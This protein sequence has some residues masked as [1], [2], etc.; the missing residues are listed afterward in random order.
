MEQDF[1][2]VLDNL[3]AVLFKGY[4]DGSIDLFDRKVESLTGYAQEEFESRRLK[5]S[6]LI[7][8]EDLDR[9][10]EEFIQ[11][12][13][14]DKAYVREFRIRNKEGGIVW[15]HE[16]SH[17]IRDGQGR[18]EYISGLFFDITEKKRLEEEL[19]QTEQEF[20]IVIDNIPAVLGKGYLDGSMDP[21]DHK[22]EAVTG[23]S[24]ED[25][26]SRRLKLTDLV[27]PEDLGRI[28][29]T[30]IQALKSNKA[31]V[32]EYRIR[33]KQGNVVWILERSHI[34]RNAQG[35]G[36]YI[37]GLFFDITESKRIEEE[38]RQ[39][40]QE[41]RIVID[42]IPAVLAKGYLD[43][44][45]DT[46]DQK[47]EFMTG[48]PR[49]EFESR[50]LKWTDLI[51]DAD[52]DEAKEIFVHALKGDKTYVR[53]YRI[54]NKRGDIIWIHERGHILCNPDGQVQYISGFFFDI[55]DRK[56]LE[57]TVAEQ[58]A[59]LKEANE[60]LMVWSK[61]LE[62]RNTEI[63]LLGQMGELLQSC[64][65]IEEAYIAIKQ[66]LQQLFPYDSGALYIFNPGRTLVEAT[67]VWGE[68]P[69]AEMVVAP[70]E[71]WALRRGRP[72]GAVEIRAGF[73]CRH[74][75]AENQAYICIPL[76][77]HGEAIGMFHVLLDSPD[78]VQSAIKQ[79]LAVRV[80]EYLGLALAKLKLQETLQRLSVRDPL[81]GLYNR[82]HLEE[83]MERELRRAERQGKQVGVIM[84]DID[85]FKRFNDTYGHEAGDALLREMGAFLQ[86]HIRGNDLAC[87]YGGEEF[88][89]IL[90]DVSTE[91]TV[92]RAEQLREAVKQLKVL[93]G[94]GFL[95]PITLS[96]GVAM[97]PAHGA[98]L[99]AVLQAADLALYRAKQTGRDRVCLSGMD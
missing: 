98:T 34:I 68:T 50:R 69:P 56:E 41:F 46:Y 93:H 16:R 48:Y 90:R 78:P 79:D 38:L 72:H 63:S 25:F 42:N 73:K 53:E 35:R 61:E 70:D 94:R 22:I 85:H 24:K 1:R 45:V 43:G 95:D 14:A 6:D 5:W 32:R 26:D 52:R 19:R 33:N 9:T 54:K 86:R 71:C 17:I 51:I 74:A 99:L 31:Y 97:F 49:E 82:R 65:T 37:S 23:Y 20:R 18:A 39:T 29:E 64:N 75:G 89:L 57:A 40:E 8:E 58:N 62:Q 87:R 7:L 91:R 77:A 4:L 28:K 83:S 76:V 30:F 2:I 44:S 96:L 81:T 12:L 15:I 47:I 66:S 27:L 3:P 55:T 10:R 60:R 36:E 88:T 84:V 59:Q 21:Y 13:K 67:A 80:S 92:Q 11:A